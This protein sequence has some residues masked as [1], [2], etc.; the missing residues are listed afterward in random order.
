META[1]IEKSSNIITHHFSFDIFLTF[2][3]SLFKGWFLYVCYL[4]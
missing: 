4:F 3:S 1:H 2:L